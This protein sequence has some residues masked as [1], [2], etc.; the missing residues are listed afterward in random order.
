MM[1]HYYVITGNEYGADLDSKK[2]FTNLDDAYKHFEEVK[3]D[4]FACR[5]VYVNPSGV[6]RDI[7]TFIN[8]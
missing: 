3:F 2:N 4:D 8:D 7:E 6:E 5:I 1:E